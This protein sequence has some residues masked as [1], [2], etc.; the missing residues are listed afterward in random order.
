MARKH[1]SKWNIDDLTDAEI[2]AAIRYLEPD[3]KSAKDQNDII[4]ATML[5]LLLGFLALILLYP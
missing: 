4:C 3:P 2:Y 1:E 5:I